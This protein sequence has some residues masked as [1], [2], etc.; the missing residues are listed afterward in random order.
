MKINELIHCEILF[1]VC[2]YK[3]IFYK[4]CGYNY[5]Y[6]YVKVWWRSCNFVKSVAYM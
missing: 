4:G 1:Y 6:N 5:N 3:T 2:E